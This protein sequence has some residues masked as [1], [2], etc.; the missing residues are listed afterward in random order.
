[1]RAPRRRGAPGARQRARTLG[2]SQGHDGGPIGFEFCDFTN[3]YFET[4]SGLSTTGATIITAGLWPSPDEQVGLPHGL[5][6]WRAL[7]HWLGGM[8]I[9]VLSLAI[10]PLLGV[11]G[12]QLYRAEVPGP[13]SDK[14]VPRVAQTARLLWAVY[15]LFSVVQFLL[16]LAGGLDPYLAA[17]HTFGTLA[18]G[19]FSVLATSA[20]GF[21]SAYVEWVTTVFMV[22]A[23]L[24]FALHFRAL[25]GRP[26]AYL[27]DPEARFFL[28][29]FGVFSVLVALL[30]LLHGISP[31]V[32]SALR[33]ASF[34]VA[35][36]VTTTGYASADFETWLAVAPLAPALLV[37]LM[38]VGGSAGSTGGGIKCVR[39]VLAAKMGYRELLRLVHPR[40]VVAV[41]LGP[42]A[43]SAQTLR[44]V[45]GF[46]LLY[47]ATFAA[48]ALLLC[49]FGVDPLSAATASAAS[50]GNIGPGLGGVGPFDSYFWLP[51]AGKWVCIAQM[52]MGR[53]EIYTVLVL[54]LPRIWSRR[55]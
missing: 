54:L 53:L 37:L 25:R 45:V 1:M 42:V 32:E 36:I 24:N 18:T 5:L 43:V 46:L 29:V 19:G 34:Q 35:S 52:L 21:D 40:A 31:D 28:G 3:A 39:V 27:K 51:T 10:L 14:L 30:L 38:F 4:M 55:I 47:L 23:G 48:G 8:G 2:R 44:A 6:F 13:T 9:I 17:T 11:G 33:T 22:A 20:A 15:L 49:A 7:T 12:M 50:V 26:G 16:L 41:R